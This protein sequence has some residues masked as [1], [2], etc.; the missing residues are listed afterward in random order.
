VL[1]EANGQASMS[2]LQLLIFTFVIAVSLFMLVGRNSDPKSNSTNKGF[3]E[4]PNGVLI[5]LGLSAS[6]YAVGKGI[7]YSRNEGVAAPDERAK[8]RDTLKQLAPEAQ[9]EA[10]KS[11]NAS[12]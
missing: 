7:S 11:G 5:L 6:T 12:V 10:V 1:A 4:I 2:R 8:S 3:P 9:V